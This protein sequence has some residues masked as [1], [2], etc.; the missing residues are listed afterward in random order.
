VQCRV[1]VGADVEADRL[2][3]GE[4]AQHRARGQASQSPPT[5]VVP[6]V[7]VANRRGTFLG[8]SR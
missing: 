3:A 5:P 2:D 1:V 4:L 7:D 8:M 6:G